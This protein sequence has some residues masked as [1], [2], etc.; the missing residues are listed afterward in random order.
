[1]DAAT[2]DAPVAVWVRLGMAIVLGVPQLV[3]GLWAV[4][5]PESWFEDFPG[6]DPRLVA[7]EPPFNRHLAT[8]AGAGFLA[9]GVVLVVAALWAR[10]SGVLI[11]LLAFAAFGVPHL[12]YHVAHPSDLLSSSEDTRNVVTLAV[13]LALA[14]VFA[15]GAWRSDDRAVSHPSEPIPHEL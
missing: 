13:P 2:T 14:A 10:R 9:T 11:A 4:L 15:W 5:A 8:D 6:F 7:A 1:M 3:V 12:A